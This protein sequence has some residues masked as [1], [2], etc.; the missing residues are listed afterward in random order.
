MLASD[1]R[2]VV[3]VAILI[4]GMAGS[5]SGNSKPSQAERLLKQAFDNLYAADAIQE[6]TISAGYRLSL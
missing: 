5:S 3:V 2:F 4:A 6:I 1:F